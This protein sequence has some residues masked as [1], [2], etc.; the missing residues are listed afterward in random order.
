MSCPHLA[1]TETKLRPEL[2]PLPDYMKHL[3]VH[4]GY[5]VPAFVHWMENGEPEFRVLEPGFF[6]KAYRQQLCW[7]CGLPFTNRRRA[8]VI[9]PMCAINRISAELP[10][11]TDCARFSAMGCPF[12]SKPTMVRRENA[13]PDGISFQEGHVEHNPTVALVYHTKNRFW[14]HDTSGGPLIEMDEPTH[15]E[16]YYAGKPANREQCMTALLVGM[17]QLRAEALAKGPREVVAMEDAIT[18]V[19]DNLVPKQ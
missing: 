16:W 12:L 8:F 4:R 17:A 6:I 10:C 5:P 19:I 7:V 3:P 14:I 1:L 11:H 9:G 2:P 18:Y 13:L 15:V